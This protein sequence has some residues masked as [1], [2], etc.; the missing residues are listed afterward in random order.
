MALN[1]EKQSDSAKTGSDL[2]HLA[3]P[4]SAAAAAEQ[5]LF[6]R[7][8]LGVDKRS[9]PPNEMFHVINSKTGQISIEVEH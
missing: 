5:K 2:K 7:I 3:S 9:L 6:Y 1:K 8:L 4:Y